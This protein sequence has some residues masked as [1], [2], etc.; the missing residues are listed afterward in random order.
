MKKTL[1]SLFAA[2]A[3]V[4]G[5][6]STQAAVLQAPTVAEATSSTSIYRVFRDRQTDFVFVRMPRGWVFV[7]KDARPGS[8][9]V[10]VDEPTGFVFVKL[11]DGWKFAGDASSTVAS[12][13]SSSSLER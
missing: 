12:N 5:L 1:Q 3:L 4:A 8:H 11:S 2:T 6:A 13:D 7:G 10:Y 9:P